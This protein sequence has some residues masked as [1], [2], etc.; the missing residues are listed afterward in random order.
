MTEV[1]EIFSNYS[2][3]TLSLMSKINK[4]KEIKKELVW[5]PR[6]PNNLHYIFN[7]VIEYIDLIA[8]ITIHYGPMDQVHTMWK[9]FST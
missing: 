7:L 2:L 1:N 8:W 6:K 9:I 4:G 5:N 3:V